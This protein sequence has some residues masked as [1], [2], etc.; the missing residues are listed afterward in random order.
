[1]FYFRMLLAA[2]NHIF[3]PPYN[4]DLFVLDSHHPLENPPGSFSPT[5][6]S[7]VN[8]LVTGVPFGV[9][10]RCLRFARGAVVAGTVAA[11]IEHLTALPPDAFMLLSCG[12]IAHASDVIASVHDECAFMEFRLR[13]GLP[14]GKGG[15]GAMLRG[16]N[17]SKKT[18][19][20]DA[21]RDLSGRRLRDVHMQQQLASALVTGL[22]AGASSSQST[23]AFVSM[24]KHGGASDRVPVAGTEE[25]HALSHGRVDG[26]G[27]SSTSEEVGRSDVTMMEQ[28]LDVE[29]LKADLEQT[30]TQVRDAVAEGIRA[31]RAL[32]KEMKKVRST[33]RKRSQ[34]VENVPVVVLQDP[35]A[36][37]DHDAQPSDSEVVSEPAVKTR[38]TVKR[39]LR[40]ERIQQQRVE[41]PRTRSSTRNRK[42]LAKTV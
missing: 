13:R 5:A 14:G 1:L 8:V 15:F 22:R 37:P 29:T 38:R 18:A 42:A 26:L 16:S 31:A 20:F 9:R 27:K 21:C 3:R 28:T 10:T 32:R 23:G 12:R 19:N 4:R 24:L 33:K 34:A 30:S 25:E 39:V 40:S 17:A 7:T 36:A 6:M 2:P 35:L 11:A 41:A